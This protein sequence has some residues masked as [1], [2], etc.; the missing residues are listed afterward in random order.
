[1]FTIGRSPLGLG[2]KRSLDVSRA[3]LAS[4]YRLTSAT[5]SSRSCTR[6]KCCLKQNLVRWAQQPHKNPGGRPAG[7]PCPGGCTDTMTRRCWSALCARAQDAPSLCYRALL[8]RLG[9][10]RMGLLGERPHF[11]H[12]ECEGELLVATSQGSEMTFQGPPAPCWPL[13]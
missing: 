1:M 5:D 9:R 4:W 7:V 11:C 6:S 12:K 2:R 10:D 8:V 3:G 13:P